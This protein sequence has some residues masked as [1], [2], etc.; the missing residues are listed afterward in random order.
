MGRILEILKQPPIAP[1]VTVPL[2]SA[3]PSTD[4]TE[5]PPDS[6][7][8]QSEE[9]PFI[10]V[11]GRGR[12]VEASS[13]VLATTP[14]VS[15]P[16]SSSVRRGT[17]GGDSTPH[18]PR[19]TPHASCLPF[20]DRGVQ[21]ASSESLGVVYQPVL[22][23]K[24]IVDSAQ[25]RIASELIAYHHPNHPI[26]EQYR[27]LLARLNGPSSGPEEWY[28]GRGPQVLLFLGT[29]TGIGTTTV[30][31]NLGITRSRF[32]KN[33]VVV[34]DANLRQ[35]AV[36]ERL[37][38]P[39]LP[40]IRELASHRVTL[41][42]ALRGTGI[43]QLWAITAGEPFSATP[44]WPSGDAVRAILQQLRSQFD[45]VLI[46]APSWDGGPE[47][48]SIGS[49]CDA[50]YLVMRPSEVKS[51]VVEELGRLIPHLGCPLS[52]YFLIEPNK[53]AA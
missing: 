8:T 5:L 52:G 16:E 38:I 6:P 32:S 22:D 43:P 2:P 30:L 35:P 31:L 50:V 15:Q 37:G 40:G 20:P 48:V 24:Q 19:L 4:S 28:V 41:P 25:Q 53:T 36:A 26:S 14:K 13:Q 11:G 49:A 51:P 44:S 18:A 33:G 9:I 10:E 47:M 1:E 34:V 3:V 7:G 23:A 29:T 46:D 45:L 12:T 27:S 42:L 17:S 39:S 21:A